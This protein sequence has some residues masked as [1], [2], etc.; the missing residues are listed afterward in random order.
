MRKRVL[1]T[2]LAVVLLL[3][4]TVLP[5][6]AASEVEVK[7]DDYYAL[8]NAATGKVLNVYYNRSANGTNVD[9]YDM[10]YTDSVYWKFTAS[11][12]N[13][14]LSP[15]NAKGSALNVYGDYAKN[16]TNVCIWSKTG[17]STQSWV[18]EAVSGGFIL[19]SANNTAVVLTAAGLR[20]N[21]NVH[22]QT[23]Q[24]GNSY[25]VWTS[26]A[27]SV[28]EEPQ[29]SAGSGAVTGSVGS[30]ILDG[31][32]TTEAQP[33]RAYI[34]DGWY[35]MTP[36]CAPNMRLD[37]NGGKNG[38]S[39]NVQIWKALGSNAQ[40][41]YVQAFGGGY[42]T[43]GTCND[44]MLLDVNKGST[45]KGTNVQQY[46][47][48]VSE[49]QKWTFHDAG[50]GYVWIVPKVSGS[51]R[52]DVNGGG[53]SNGT[54]VQ[55]WT[56]NNS[57]AQ[58]WKLTPTD[59]PEEKKEETKPEISTETSKM[60][61]VLNINWDNR[62]AVGKQTPGTT[63]CGCYALAYSRT[64]LDGFAHKWSEYDSTQ[65]AVWSRAGY[66]HDTSTSQTAT[67]KKA[68]DEINAGR[69]AILWVVG[70]NSPDTHYVTVVGYT[71]VDPENLDSLS[72]AN[73]L[74]IDPLRGYNNGKYTNLAG[75]DNY[76]LQKGIISGNYNCI[77]I[78]S[79]STPNTSA[80]QPTATESGVWIVTVPAQ[81]YLSLYAK[82]A[83]SRESSSIY[84]R[85]ASY[86]VKCHTKA[87]VNGTAWY[88]ASI[89]DH[90]TMRDYW[91]KYGRGMTVR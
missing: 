12:S 17:H 48:I 50:D 5:A 6:G 72:E 3:G 58:K 52:L 63:S 81:Y 91:F 49:A 33:Q 37:V 57:D 25:Q 82:P 67:L 9:L 13:Y 8:Y 59:G 51:L 16:G 42:Y 69:P 70:N 61:K 43:I 79:S 80:T 74:I 55:V 14:V 27:L 84:R 19:R 35:T 75:T 89:N 86:P 77:R 76:R 38:D 2:L 11:G 64:I 18:V 88:C 32:T 85:P 47:S 39:V 21:S 78:R 28:K 60:E 87:T 53:S 23:Y 45:A 66:G 56:K 34:S 73:F 71:G 36:K 29:T 1:S 26:D 30:I 15:R 40:K 46:H 41:F 10:D 20:N 65:G 62:A 31:G 4:V 22:L 83:D 24:P 54:N 90:G 44:D 7:T 68:Y